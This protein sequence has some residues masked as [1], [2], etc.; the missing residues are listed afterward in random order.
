MVL[1]RILKKNGI[2]ALHIHW[3]KDINLAVLVKLLSRGKLKIVYT[4]QMEIYGDKHDWYHKFIYRNVDLFLTISR[5]LVQQASKLLPIPKE[6]IKLIYYGTPAYVPGRESTN[7]SVRKKYDIQDSDFLVGVIGRIEYAKGQHLLVEAIELLH[8]SNIPAHA[9][10]VGNAQ[11]SDYLAKLK[12]DVKQKDLESSVHFIEFINNPK[13][14]MHNCDVVILTTYTET[15]GLV[16]IEAMS[17]GTAVVGTDSGGVPEIIKDGETGLLFKPGDSQGLADC[18]Q[19][20]FREPDL[21]KKLAENGEK[22][23]EKNFNESMHY[24]KLFGLLREVVDNGWYYCSQSTMNFEEF[25]DW[26]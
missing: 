19:K 22:L 9:L 8:R 12:N 25:A 21:R 11:D 3:S 10:I 14:V 7:Q 6:R 17:A 1:H 5:K 2:I 24:E 13:D 26:I 15:F 18:L 20:L 23:V 4:R 16:L